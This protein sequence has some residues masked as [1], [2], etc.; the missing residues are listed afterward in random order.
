MVGDQEP[1]KLSSE[2]YE[3]A[4]KRADARMKSK[5]GHQFE[6]ILK[7]RCIHCGRSPKAK[8]KCGG[9]FQTFIECLRQELC[10]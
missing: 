1:G 5:N 9:W 6:T 7:T 8:G 10:Q 3:E 2:A 4:C